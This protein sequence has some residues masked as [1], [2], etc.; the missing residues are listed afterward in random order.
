MRLQEFE[1]SAAR[2]DA[3]LAATA[4][5]VRKGMLRNPCDV[6]HRP[7]S[8]QGAIRRVAACIP[9][10]TPFA[11]LERARR[12]LQRAKEQLIELDIGDE[13]AISAPA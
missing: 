8:M 2:T 1:Q 7:A 4:H 12:D 3:D 13:E 9:P 11:T 10:V 6:V 5:A